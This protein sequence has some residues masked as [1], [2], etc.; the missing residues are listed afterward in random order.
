MGSRLFLRISATDWVEGGWDVDQSVEL[1]CPLSPPRRGSGGL[2]FRRA[3]PR[4]EDSQ[5]GEADVVLLARQLLRNPYWPLRA[6]RV[7]GATVAWPPQY[8]RAVD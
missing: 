5:E 1:T 3:R 2:F 4:S 6:A 7:L 8:Q